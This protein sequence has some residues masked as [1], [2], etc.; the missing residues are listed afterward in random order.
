MAGGK[1]TPRQKMIGM[2]Y[3]VLTALLA[4]NIA[5]EI[6]DAF[7]LVNEGMEIT[8]ANFEEKNLTLYGQFETAA[9]ENQNKFGTAYEKALLIQKKC[10]ELDEYIGSIKVELIRETEGLT[11]AEADTI[12][13]QYVD[14]KDNFDVT[15]YLMCGDSDDGTDGLASELRQRIETFKTEVI[16][17]L[18]PAS[19]DLNLGLA[20][21]GNVLDGVKQNWEMRNFYHMQLA[22]AVVLLTKLQTEIR[23][24]EYDV[25]AS[26]YGDVSAE[27]FPFDT[28][29]AKVVAPSNYVLLGEEYKADVFVAAYSTSQEPQVYLGDYD[30]IT[31]ALSGNADSLPVSGGIGKY[32]VK[33]D[34]EGI[35]TYRGVMQ[36]KNKKGQIKSYP[37][38]SEYMVARPTATVSADAMN[39]FYRGVNNPISVSVPGIPDEQVS[40][41]ISGAT[42]SRTGQGKYNVRMANSGPRTVD[43]RIAAKMSDGTTKPMATA[44]YR[45][46]NLPAPVATVGALT[47]GKIKKRDIRIQQG[48]RVKY[49]DDFIFDLPAKA[50]SFK[51]S[52]KANGNLIP[53]RTI[54]GNRFDRD[55]IKIIEALGNGDMV[56]IEKIK[57]KDASGKT[58]T[59]NP[60]TLL[61]VN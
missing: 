3:L 52:V 44:T 58:L 2:M 40:V 47:G 56:F 14:A 43:V 31:Y 30:T 38:E 8:N 26:L 34:R 36:V 42:L 45:I 25:I 5:K 46:K 61:V 50:S 54:Q 19:K 18:P 37:F 57:F 12:H 49:G 17:L 35:H 28:V 11:Q 33:A 39:V 29:V 60:I 22:P 41:S 24:A 55:A 59:L 23:N 9:N 48:V 4:L 51:F 20:L 1:E 32:V 13:L 27:D 7:V 21:E 16:N 15:T 10:N 53:A 6:L